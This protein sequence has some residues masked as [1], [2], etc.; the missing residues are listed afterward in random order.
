[1]TQNSLISVSCSPDQISDY[2]S[3]WLLSG[4]LL[5]YHLSIFRSF[6]PGLKIACSINPFHR[7]LHNNGTQRTSSRTFWTVIPISCTYIGFIFSFSPL[8]AYGGLGFIRISISLSL[9]CILIVTSSDWLLCTVLQTTVKPCHVTPYSVVNVLIAVF[10]NTR[11]GQTF[12]AC[13]AIS[14]T[15]SLHGAS[16][17]INN[18]RSTTSPQCQRHLQRNSG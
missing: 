6:I 17:R 12:S 13:I 11:V 14:C 1:M 15:F 9:S 7:I 2:L 10:Q 16:F 3:A 4:H 8:I 18:T 5:W